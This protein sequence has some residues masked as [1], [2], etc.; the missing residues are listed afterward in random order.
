MSTRVR[1]DTVQ[2]D[3]Y[4][5][6]Y[7][8]RLC[9]TT[10]KATVTMHQP[11][12]IIYKEMAT[13]QVSM[14]MEVEMKAIRM[15]TT[16]EETTEV[17]AGREAEVQG[18]EEEEE[19]M[20]PLPPVALLAEEEEGQRLAA[21]TRLREMVENQMTMTMTMTLAPGQG[22]GEVG[23]CSGLQTLPVSA[24][25]DFGIRTNSASLLTGGGG[26]VC[27]CQEPAVERTVSKEGD[28]KGRKF[29]ACSKPREEGCGFFEWAGA[30]AGRPGGQQAS[31]KR[32]A[33]DVVSVIGDRLCVNKI[34]DSSHSS[35]QLVGV[36]NGC[37]PRCH[38]DLTAVDR[39]SKKEVSPWSHA[40]ALG[41]LLM[42]ALT[43]PESGE[44]IL[45]ML[46]IIRQMQLVSP[47]W[48]AI[49][50]PALLPC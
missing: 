50:S 34:A 36:G 14:T 33:A 40:L 28:N 31:R 15:M 38:C 29:Y 35:L 49:I 23:L 26:I 5:T 39:T 22:Q 16:R 18:A 12:P 46:Q 41:Q 25:A 30:D 17:Q 10:S 6:V 9:A 43:G 27:G 7:P 2:A 48:T 45:D 37:A 20:L 44:I 1:L 21:E 19:E 4:R 8:S 13:V 32:T 11:T 3:P 42:C 47:C 24:Y